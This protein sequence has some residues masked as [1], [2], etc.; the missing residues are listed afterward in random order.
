MQQMFFANPKLESYDGAC[1][2]NGTA[3]MS[4]DQK[5]FILVLFDRIEDLRDKIRKVK[6]SV[7]KETVLGKNI[8]LPF[9]TTSQIELE[10]LCEK[11]KRLNSEYTFYKSLF[12]HL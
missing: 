10:E 2:G 9:Q 6:E 1:C 11:A 7:E 12:L 4:E 8:A 5:K 3:A